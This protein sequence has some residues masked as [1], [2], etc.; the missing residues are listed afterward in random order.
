MTRTTAPAKIRKMA[1]EAVAAARRMKVGSGR[2]AS[3]LTGHW[4]VIARLH[5]EL[6]GYRR[7]F[8]EAALRRAK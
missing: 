8:I 5:P 7:E 4:Q 1:D 2:M 3:Y 6:A